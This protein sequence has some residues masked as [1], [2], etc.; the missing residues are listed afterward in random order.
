MHRSNNDTPRESSRPN[1]EHDT[2]EEAA[3]V[4]NENRE[5]WERIADSDLALSRPVKRALEAI[6]DE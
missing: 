2:L 1:V 6:D 4:I 5:L 3:A